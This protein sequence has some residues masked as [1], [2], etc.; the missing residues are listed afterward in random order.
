M[1]YFFQLPD[2]VGIPDSNATRKPLSA[3]M[4]AAIL[5]GAPPK[6]RIR[7]SSFTEETHHGLYAFTGSWRSPVVCIYAR[8]V[9]L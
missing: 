6:K 7:S 9:C 4:A 1:V 8:Y 3:A 5:K 2:N